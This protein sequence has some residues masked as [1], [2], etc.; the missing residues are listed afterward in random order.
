MKDIMD[1]V[2]RTYGDFRFPTLYLFC[3][4]I[5]LIANR[6]WRRAFVIAAIILSAAILN[7]LFYS[8]W[9]RMNEAMVY[10]RAIWMVPV[11]PVCA[12]TVALGV[13]R[14]HNAVKKTVIVLSGIVVFA[15]CGQMMYAPESQTST[16]VLVNNADKLP[17]DVVTV[18]NALLRLDD[19][20][21]VVTDATLSPYLR[22]YSGR[23]HAAYSRS[24]IYGTP[25]PLGKKLYGFLTGGNY[26]DLSQM[27]ANYDYPYLVTENQSEEK[28]ATLE[29]SGF[30]PVEVVSGYGIYRVTTARTELREYNELGQ[31]SMLTYLDGAGKPTEGQDGYTSVCYEYD[32][33]GRV[34]CELYRDIDGNPA[35][36]SMGIAGYRRTYNKLGQLTVE[37]F[38]GADGKPK[39]LSYATRRFDYNRKH[40]LVSE[41][42][43]DADDRLMLR[44]DKGYASRVLS[45]NREGQI[46]SEVFFG[47]SGEPAD[48][49]S[50]YSQIEYK[51]TESGTLSCLYFYDANGARLE[52]GSSYFHEYLESLSGRNVTV[53]IS[54]RDDG[55]YALTQTLQ[56]DLYCLGIRT[57]L[58]GRF[59]SSYYAV[60]SPGQVVEEISDT[61]LLKYTGELDGKPYSIT[62]GGFFNGHM[63]S[64]VFDGVECSKNARGMNIAVYDWEQHAIVEC[65]AFD[66]C[67]RDMLVTR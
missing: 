16:F 38:L 10:W 39:L 31:V 53:F 48:T 46:E 40:Q 66:T 24:A 27:M 17:E 15:L 6:A 22:Q 13:E 19:T 5:S 32:E 63:S 12:A 2:L 64:I 52:C 36:N 51:Y 43:Y 41:S 62:S 37:T 45:Y 47:L 29:A 60:I 8:L 3:L 9:A 58:I 30:E 18:G 44:A 26:A 65:I 49:L 59:R 21:R 28:R 25:S 55:S 33:F 35:L 34:S 61:Q 23:I 67:D 20:P 57:N 54:V 4:A 7:P 1:A 14:Q 50:G 11:V 56:D 42:Y